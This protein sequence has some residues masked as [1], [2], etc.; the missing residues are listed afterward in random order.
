MCG[1]GFDNTLKAGAFL[2]QFLGTFGIVPNGWR[3]KFAGDFD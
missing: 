1:E 2:A 3:F